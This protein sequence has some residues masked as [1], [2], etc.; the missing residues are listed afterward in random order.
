MYEA[1]G[2]ESLTARGRLHLLQTELAA[3]PS[4]RYQDLFAGCLLC[5]ACEQAC[6]RKINIRQLV[7]EARANFPALYGKH[8]MRKAAVRAVLSRPRLLEGLALAGV[9]LKNLALLPA[10]SGLRLKLGVLEQKKKTG[11]RSSALVP[12]TS[13]AGGKTVSYFTGCL[14][15]FLQPSVAEATGTLCRVLAG[16]EAGIP[17]AQACCGLAAWSSGGPA[18]ARRLAEKNI[19]AFADH[20]GPILTSCASCSFFLRT[21]PDLFADDPAWHARA[22]SFAGRVTE[23]SAFF[24]PLTSGRILRPVSP[25]NLYYHEPCH[26]RFDEKSR[27]SSLQLLGRISTVTRLDTPETQH[28]CGQGGLFHVGY[29]ALSEKIF[30]RAYGAVSSAE[31]GTVVTTCSGCLMQWQAGLA[32]RQ[33]PLS[34]RH[35]A[36][37]LV[38]CLAGGQRR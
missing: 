4:S 20:E 6:P 19:T 2:R 30:S 37:L 14:A 3:R 32:T 35:L 28:C 17:D 36:N 24:L 33:S 5:G 22:V 7:V 1:T 8:G 11:G 38:E 13:E 12:G 18:E 23:F 27:G 10:D 9:R 25:L 26:L 29:P 31:S 34:A 15:R 16:S 21:Y